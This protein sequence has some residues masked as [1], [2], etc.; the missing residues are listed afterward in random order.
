MNL[1]VRLPLW[2]PIMRCSSDLLGHTP[3]M[4]GSFAGIEMGQMGQTTQSSQTGPCSAPNPPIHQG[5]PQPVQCLTLAAAHPTSTPSPLAAGQS[6]WERRISV[7]ATLWLRWIASGCAHGGCGF[8]GGG[9][10]VGPPVSE[11]IKIA[12]VL[13][14]GGSSSAEDC[15]WTG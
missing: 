1:P 3:P 7:F 2:L 8:L 12:P 9:R 5:K 14:V 11:V 4:T 10:R 6:K 13:G 15:H